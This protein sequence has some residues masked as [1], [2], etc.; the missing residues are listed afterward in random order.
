MNHFMH[1]LTYKEEKFI[2]HTMMLIA[3]LTSYSKNKKKGKNWKIS[4][5]VVLIFKLTNI[6]ICQSV[7]FVVLIIIHLF[8]FNTI[9]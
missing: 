5:H 1:C 2:V 7:A 4:V 9:F 6:N 8:S 3:D